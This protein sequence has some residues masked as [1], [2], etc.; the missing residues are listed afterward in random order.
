MRS[1]NVTESS[2]V[3]CRP[4]LRPRPTPCSR[5]LLSTPSLTVKTLST[6]T[7]LIFRSLLPPQRLAFWNATYCYNSAHFL[8]Y[9]LAQ[10]QLWYVIKPIYKSRFRDRFPL[11]CGNFPPFSSFFSNIIIIEM[12]LLS[13]HFSLIWDIKHFSFS[14]CSGTRRSSSSQRAGH[15]LRRHRE[16]HQRV[17]RKSQAQ[18]GQYGGFYFK[19]HSLN[20]PIT[21]SKNMTESNNHYLF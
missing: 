21:W 7:T 3:S 4:S 12:I 6:E 16:R 10:K 17:G 18:S 20:L 13:D 14:Q 9:H 8:L 19:M 11:L 5:R 15:E 2:S 1:W